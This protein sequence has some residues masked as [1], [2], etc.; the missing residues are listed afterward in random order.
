VIGDAQLGYA[1]PHDLAGRQGVLRNGIPNFHHARSSPGA[2]RIAILTGE[3]RRSASVRH[4]S[5]M[6]IGQP[7]SSYRFRQGFKRLPMYRIREVDGQDDEIAETL[8]D[9]HRLTFFDGASIP[10][11]DWGYWWMAYQETVPVA[12]AGVI[13]S[14]VRHQCRISF[15]CRRAEKALRTKASIAPDARWNRVHD[16]TDGAL[17]FRIPPK[18]SLPPIILSVPAIGSIGRKRPGPGRTRCIG[19]SSSCSA[20]FNL[21]ISIFARWPD[22]AAGLFSLYGSGLAAKWRNGFRTGF[23]TILAFTKHGFDMNPCGWS[24]YLM[25]RPTSPDVVAFSKSPGVTGRP[26]KRTAS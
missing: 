8:A 15:P 19:A 6:L 11:F 25:Q 16:L 22:R 18:I 12:F 23:E 17:W 14:N 7:G 5:I 20:K 1:S 21:R 9:L 24:V 4:A 3:W 26:S 2:C 13:P 10:A